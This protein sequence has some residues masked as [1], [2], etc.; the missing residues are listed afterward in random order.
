[1]SLS[2]RARK[3]LSLFSRLQQKASKLKYLVSPKT[4][5]DKAVEAY[6][7]YRKALSTERK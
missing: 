1:M 2:K 5:V 7:I 6:L 3:N 4:I